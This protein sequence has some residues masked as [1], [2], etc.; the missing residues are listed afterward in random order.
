M[1]DK[2]PGAAL[3]GLSGLPATKQIGLFI[4][5]AA[6]VS[7][8]IYLALWAQTPDYVPVLSDIAD[9]QRSEAVELLSQS[10]IPYTVDPHTGMI[11]VPSQNLQTA[12][13]AL[14]R[15]GITGGG[16][17]GFEL[18]DKDRGFGS[19]QFQEQTRYTRGLQGELSKT[20]SNI[21]YIKKARVHLAIP[22]STAFLKGQ[23]TPTA[24]VFVELQGGRNLERNQ[25]SAIKNL[26]AA[27]IPGMKQDQVTVIDQNG[28][29]LASLGE[30]SLTV[31]SRQIDYVRNVEDAYSKRIEQL[32]SPI[33]GPGRV[34][35]EVTARMDF[36]EREETAENYDPKT[37]IIRSEKTL[38][39]AKGEGDNL[40]GGVPGAVSNQPPA[41]GS[42]PETAAAPAKG[43]D[44]PGEIKNQRRQATRNFE[45][46]H[47]ITHVKATVGTLERIS[48]AVVID[49]KLEMGSDGIVKQSPVSDEELKKITQ[50]VKDAVG[51]DEKRG[52][53][54]SV[55]HSTFAKEAPPADDPPVPFY[56][57]SWFP[58]V[59][60]YSLAAL[61]F[62]L[63]LFV[64]LRPLTKNLAQRGKDDFERMEKL[65]ALQAGGNADQ[66][67]KIGGK[68]E[69]ELL[70][71]MIN[72]DPK[73]VAQVVMGWV[74][75]EDA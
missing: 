11:L 29:L 62:I 1:A 18:M 59:I 57:A 68:S 32:L 44:A 42:A 47:A 67:R 39:E 5:L 26:V 50:L 20:I 8:G 24:S 53:V 70:N 33:I 14:A 6:S 45:M 55:I 16:A 10:Q 13:L 48:V 43:K 52:D 51:F 30:D 74:G 69:T 4:G 3:A 19:S 73:R 28:N 60:R 7:L 63:I 25:V 46:D 23:R 61:G 36:T 2:L 12:R 54:V 40:L 56:E 75:S 66:R 71:E 27:S 35:A 31:A 49:D 41:A 64:V 17:E 38:E 22:K 21:K 58:L 9:G 65:I 72:Q 34:H 37:H 15:E